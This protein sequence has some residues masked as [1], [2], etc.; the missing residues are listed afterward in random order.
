MHPDLMK[1][2]DVTLPFEPFTIK[3]CNKLKKHREC[4][5]RSDC[6][7]MNN[8]CMDNDEVHNNVNIRHLLVDGEDGEVIVDGE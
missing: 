3:D 6:S 2:L 1:K 5:Y 7:W 8:K 4:V